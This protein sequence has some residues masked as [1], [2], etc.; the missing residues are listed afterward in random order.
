MSVAAGRAFS[1]LTWW[2]LWGQADHTA[3]LSLSHTHTHMG[4]ANHS[5]FINLKPF[6]KMRYMLDLMYVMSCDIKS[7]ANYQ[8]DAPTVYSIDIGCT[9]GLPWWCRGQKPVCQCRGHGLDPWSRAISHAMEWLSP[10]MPQ[11]LR[12]NAVTTEVHVP[13]T[14]AP[15]QVQFSSVAQSC[16]IHCD[17]MDCSTPGFPVHHQPPELTQ[18]HFQWV[19]DAIQPSHPLSSP[20]PPA[21]NISQH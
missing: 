7:K 6:L 4:D 18:T 16:L 19:S 15:Q 12:P 10:Y 2:L 1:P 14:C 8:W 9:L 13:R 17:P 3:S 20:S 11:L 5:N 21:F